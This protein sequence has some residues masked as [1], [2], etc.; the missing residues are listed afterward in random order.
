MKPH[1][2]GLDHES[3]T[4]SAPAVGTERS[5]VGAAGRLGKL[6][7]HRL[8]SACSRSSYGSG[9]PP[10]APNW[11]RRLL[12]CPAATACGV[13]AGRGTN[14]KPAGW[15][16]NTG[17]RGPRPSVRRRKRPE[18]PALPL[19]TFPQRACPPLWPYKVLKAAGSSY[20]IVLRHELGHCNGWSGDHKKARWVFSNERLAMPELP[21]SARELPVYPPIV[22]VT[23]DWKQESCKDRK[24]VRVNIS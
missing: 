2:G 12:A 7:H 3:P 1:L 4:C 19:P 20:A 10:C 24:E 18:T 6:R 14:S 21:A 15:D 23:P 11:R 13:S 17:S 22:C 9:S 16:A 8:Y 5:S